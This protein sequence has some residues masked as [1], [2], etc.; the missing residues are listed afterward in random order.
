MEVKKPLAIENFPLFPENEHKFGK[1]VFCSLW[2]LLL[3]E[4]GCNSK[5]L[6]SKSFSSI[7]TIVV[8][9]KLEKLLKSINGR[10]KAQ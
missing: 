10:S 5:C 1:L 6:L 7:G 2:Q 9:L 4:A 8:A 3:S